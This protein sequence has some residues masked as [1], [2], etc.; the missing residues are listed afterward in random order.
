MSLWRRENHT[1]QLFY[2]EGS[3]RQAKKQEN[4]LTQDLPWCPN[5]FE[6]ILQWPGP[7]DWL[8]YLAIIIE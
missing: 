3:E 1:L 7:S 5:T 2:P 4:G 6:E 8:G